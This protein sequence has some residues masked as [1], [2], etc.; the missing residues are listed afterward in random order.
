MD[1]AKLN[2]QFLK[3]ETY[4]S[5]KHLFKNYIKIYKLKKYILKLLKKFS[6]KTNKLVKKPVIE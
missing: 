4:F 5:T 2:L 1:N 6:L 3:F